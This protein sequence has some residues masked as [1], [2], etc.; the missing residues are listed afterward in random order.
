MAIDS[1][2][3]GAAREDQQRERGR[4]PRRFSPKN[5]S[6]IKQ[7]ADGGGE[8]D[9]RQRGHQGHQVVPVTVISSSHRG[10]LLAAICWTR[11]WTVACMTSSSGAGHRPTTSTADGQHSED[12]ELAEVEIL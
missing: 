5:T 3:N 7:H 4:E 2:D 10:N 6:A 9:L 1:G 8:I 11:C 12:D